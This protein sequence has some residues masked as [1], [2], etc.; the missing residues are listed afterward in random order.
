MFLSTLLGN[1]NPDLVLFPG[2]PVANALSGLCLCCTLYKEYPPHLVCLETPVSTSEAA[3]SRVSCSVP[4]SLM[5]STSPHLWTT[6][7]HDFVGWLVLVCSHT[8]E[9]RHL[10]L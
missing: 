2:I 5:P 6:V 4:L 9:C 3:H 7:D 8:R 10:R 1:L